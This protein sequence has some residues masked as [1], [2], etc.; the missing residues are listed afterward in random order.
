[1][2]RLL[3]LF[4]LGLILSSAARAAPDAVER[5]FQSGNA[6]MEKRDYAGALKQYRIVL[7]A[8]P[9]EPSSLWNAGSAAFFVGDTKAAATYFARL[10]KQEPDNGALLAKRIQSAQELGDL[11]A[12]DVLRARM[13]ALH[14][15]GKDKTGYAAKPSYCRD[16]FFVGHDL[17]LA[18]EYFELKPLSGDRDKPYLGR[19]YDFVAVAPDDST[20][21]RVEC[22]WSSLD[23]NPDGTFAPSRDLPSFYYDAYFPKGEWARRTYGLGPTEP[24]FEAAKK[25]VAAIL[26]GRAAQVSGQKREAN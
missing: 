4:L 17:V 25:Q 20:R 12:R 3:L 23:V 7:A 5:A 14:K 2:K 19:V 10:A 13:F 24:T 15:S 6:L 9:D 21:V 1:M 8:Q 18:F 16:Q 11:G 26:Q 22:G